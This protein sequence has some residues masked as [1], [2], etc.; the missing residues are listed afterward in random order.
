M[1]KRMALNVLCF[2]DRSDTYPSSRE[3]E[4]PSWIPTHTGQIQFPRLTP[5][6]FSI[7]EDERSRST[8]PWQCLPRRRWSCFHYVLE[9]RIRLLRT[10]GKPKWSESPWRNKGQLLPQLTF[11]TSLVSD[12][13]IEAVWSR[14]TTTTR[15]D[16]GSSA[17]PVT[18]LER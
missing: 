17:N 14:D 3:N 18:Q 16:P 11:R 1:I 10:V 7:V 13:T 2:P 5:K 9:R 8:T 12:S 15:R 4:G 6:S